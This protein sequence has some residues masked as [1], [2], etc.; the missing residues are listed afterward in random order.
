VNGFSVLNFTMLGHSLGKHLEF[1]ASVYNVFNKKYFDAGRPE[2]P[3]DT[4]QQEG[5]NFRIKLTA[6]F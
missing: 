4:I 6:K 3:E 2:D 1:S 5:R